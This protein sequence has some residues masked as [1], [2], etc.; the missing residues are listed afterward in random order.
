MAQ[1]A[2]IVSGLTLKDASG[3]A[4]E[5]INQK[6][7]SVSI[8]SGLV[9]SNTL[10]IGTTYEALLLGD[11][12]TNGGPGYFENMDD[13]NYVDVGLEVSATFIP[14]IRLFPGQRVAICSLPNR[15]VFARFN[16]AAGQL[17]YRI[18]EP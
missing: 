6:T 16:T 18:W 13:T 11:V 2:S 3:V 17:R 8:A 15:N 5:T 12:A 7:T 9:A 10:T 4:L 1:T 14:F